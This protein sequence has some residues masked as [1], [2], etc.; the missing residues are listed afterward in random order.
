MH[1]E[2]KFLK[3]LE[4]LVFNLKSQAKA[5][6]LNRDCVGVSLRAQRVL[7]FSAFESPLKRCSDYYHPLSNA[8]F[9]LPYSPVRSIFEP[10]LNSSER[11]VFRRC[12]PKGIQMSRFF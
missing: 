7:D 1:H 8:L 4:Q 2:E 9:G 3:G 11:V 5:K 12:G 10:L 6:I